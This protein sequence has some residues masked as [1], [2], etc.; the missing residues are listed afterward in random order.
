VPFL[1]KTLAPVPRVEEKRLRQLIA[2]LDDDDFTV[3]EKATAELEKL[4]EAAEPALRKAVEDA[5][6]AEV[7]QRA[8]ALV[9]KLE[10]KSAG[11]RWRRLRALEVL[12][13][14][15]TPEARQLL[16]KLAEGAPEARFTQEARASL[17]R[18]A[19]RTP[20]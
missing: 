2:E 13:Q 18:L 11:E 20:P 1:S 17:R 12:E 6:S 16:E 5:A 10:G 7:R 8:K 15:G 4:A 14:A 9:D 3:R 19:R